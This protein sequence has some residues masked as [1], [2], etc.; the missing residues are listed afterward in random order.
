MKEAPVPLQPLAQLA[1]MRF[2]ELALSIYLPTDQGAGRNYYRALLDDLARSDLHKLMEKERTALR[3]ELP[4]VLAALEKRR[5]GCPALAVFSC[6]P[7]QFIRTWRMAEP[8]SGRLAVADQLDL[9]PI[10]LQLFEHPPALAAI[11]DKRRAR[12]YSLVLDE[13]T[14]VDHL[15]GIP[16]HRHKQGGWS[17]TALQRREDEHTRWNLREVAAAI[18]GQL[19]PGGYGRL[20]L[21]GPQEARTEL[22]ELLPERALQLLTTEGTIPLYSTGNELADRLRGLD[23]RAQTASAPG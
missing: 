3:R 16:I 8:V 6:R 2:P 11:I 21:A 22:K 19:E 15:E 10:R 1:G 20:I 9:A 7:R 5:F 18:A 13:L 4:V 23:H 14:E 17:A 12:L